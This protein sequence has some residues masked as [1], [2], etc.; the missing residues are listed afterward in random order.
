VRGFAH[1][2]VLERLQEERIA[3]DSIVGCSV[4]G[5][6]GA[7]YAALGAGLDEMRGIGRSM[8]GRALLSHAWSH[9]S[10]RPERAR[11]GLAGKILAPLAEASFTR[12]HRGV[13]RLGITAFDLIRRRELV[14][15]GGGEH[16]DVT[17]VEAAIGGSAIPVLFPPKTVRR[18]GRAYRLVDAGFLDALPI[19]AALEPPFEAA[20][21]V[22]VDLSIRLG[23]RQSRASYWR[24]LRDRFGE[25]L[26]LLRP[27]VKRFGTVLF[28]RRDVGAI[29]DA[30]R[31]SVTPDVVRALRFPTKPG[32]P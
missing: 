3:V 4:G 11:T 5:L 10:R 12:L 27:R 28:L 32:S 6:V 8:S 23:W 9:W 19:E 14:F 21:V 31:A 1:I 22:A 25:R 2:G 24:D 18:G 30:G 26:I 20:T 7:F 16:R 17:V 13:Q 29:V 15:H